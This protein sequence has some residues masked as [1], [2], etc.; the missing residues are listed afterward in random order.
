MFITYTN[1][2]YEYKKSPDQSA[3]EIVHHPVIVVG[4]GPV[5]M[6]A[7][8]DLGQYGNDVLVLDDNNTVSVGSR[9]VCYSKRALEVLDRL[10]CAERMIEKGVTWNVGKIFF[11][12]ELVTQFDLLPEAGHK[13]PAFINLQQY[14]LEE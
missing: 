7:A 6:G 9:A 10:G 1:P 12:D 5:G 13:I 8:L 14:Y 2:V 11:R 4:A 3:T